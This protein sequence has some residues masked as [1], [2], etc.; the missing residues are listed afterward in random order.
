MNYNEIL[1][2]EGDDTLP[3]RREMV[4]DDT[5]FAQIILEVTACHGVPRPDSISNPQNV[6]ANLSEF[7]VW[8]LGS[9]HW[10]LFSKKFSWRANTDPWRDSPDPGIDIL[11][12]DENV[13]VLMVIEVKSSQ[14]DGSDLTLCANKSETTLLGNLEYNVEQRRMNM[15][16]NETGQAGIPDPE[17][18]PTAKRRRFSAEYKSRILE[19]TDACTEPGQIGALLRREGIYSSYLSRWRR[20]QD[21]GQS[22]ALN[23]KKRGPKA[24]V[25]E[26]L[27]KEMA[28]LQRENERL[29]ARL[30]QAETIIEVQKKLSQ[31]LGLSP[32]ESE[33]RERQ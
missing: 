23:P 32:V 30:A 7:C 19:E 5:Q 8:E 24:S 29:Q 11:A 6:R 1:S 3:L 15:S 28:K 10:R 33:S 25:D 12:T 13:K 18:I 27:A 17:V 16:R 4:L 14:D 22:E 20:E 31:L 21:Q 9:E 2:S 26:A